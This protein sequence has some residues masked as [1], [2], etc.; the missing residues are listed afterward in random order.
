VK[1][2]KSGAVPKERCATG[3]VVWRSEEFSVTDPM[4]PAKVTA[5]VIQFTT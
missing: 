3:P 4:I 1:S 5:A 2:G